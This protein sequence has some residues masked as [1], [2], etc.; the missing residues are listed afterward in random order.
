[1][2]FESLQELLA[3]Y[4]TNLTRPPHLQSTSK[5]VSFKDFFVHLNDILQNQFQ[6]ICNITECIVKQGQNVDYLCLSMT[7]QPF[8]D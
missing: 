2:D 7:Q 6:L 8:S 1:M 4:R 3:Q 5:K